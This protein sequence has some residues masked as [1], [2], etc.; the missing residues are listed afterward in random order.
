MR[1]LQEKYKKYRDTRVRVFNEATFDVLSDEHEIN[2][3]TFQTKV[4][5]LCN[6]ANL[7]CFQ[8]NDASVKTVIWHHLW[9]KIR[10]AGI[11]AEIASKEINDIEA[12]FDDYNGFNDPRWDITIRYDRLLKKQVVLKAGSYVQDYLNRT[13]MFL[14]KLTVGNLIKLNKTVNLA[15]MYSKFV[16]QNA[17]IKFIM[18]NYSKD[19]IWEIHQHLLDIGYTSD[20]T[21]L[22]LM[23]DLGFQVIKPDIVI[24]R[25]FLRNGWLHDVIPNLP[26]DITEDDLIGKGKYRSRYQYTMPLVYKAVI[27]LARAIVRLVKTQDL[28]NDLGW[29][30]DNPIREFDIFMVKFGQEPERDWGLTLNL[31]KSEGVKIART[32]KCPSLGG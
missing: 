24:S 10:Y 4:T 18:A 30:T 1:A 9:T 17:P 15:R 28:Q 13:G 5:D 32:S 3:V 6:S 8:S 23:M 2:K 22:H 26:T 27:D 29:V 19:D 12:I 20:L 21:A 11:K 16:Q 14:G 25:L 7:E 31:S